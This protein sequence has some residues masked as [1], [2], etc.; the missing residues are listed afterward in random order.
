MRRRATPAR[1]LE[2]GFTL[3]ELL[4]VLVIIGLLAGLVGPQVL[5]YLS[6][7][8]SDTAA[9]QIEQLLAALELFVLDVGQYPTARE[10]LGA[11]VERPQGVARWNGPYLRKAKVPLDPW[12]HPYVYRSRDDGAG[13]TIISLGADGAVGGDGENRDIERR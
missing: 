9:A 1:S 6:S 12:G 5:R 2:R 13:A 7:A 4:V 8:K 3:I 10:G 11:L